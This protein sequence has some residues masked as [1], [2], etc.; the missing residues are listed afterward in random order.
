MKK[1][2]GKYFLV[3]FAVLLVLSLTPAAALAEKIDDI[4]GPLTL[5]SGSVAVGD[6]TG[7]TVTIRTEDGML[8][9]G[10][11]ILWSVSDEKT[12]A[13]KQDPNAADSAIIT[14]KAS[15][16][17][18]ITAQIQ[19]TDGSFSY[20]VSKATI[21]VKGGGSSDGGKKNSGGSDAN[22]EK[23]TSLGSLTAEKGTLKVGESTDVVVTVITG[24]S[25]TLPKG[26]SIKWSVSDGKAASVTPDAGSP[27]SATVK[28]LKAKDELTVSAQLYDSDGDKKGGPSSTVIRITDG[29]AAPAPVAST[30]GETNNIT[31]GPITLE[32]GS[33]AV[34]GTS[35]GVAT[36]RTEDGKLPAG[37]SIAWTSSDEALA[38]VTPKEGAPEEA[39]ITGIAPGAEVAIT[40]Q[41]LDET[42]A[43]TNEISNTV[44]EITGEAAADAF[45]PYF[46]ILI[47]VIIAV[48]VI[49]VA[50]L[51]TRSKRARGRRK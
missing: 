4:L 12:A 7:A 6:T 33:I 11:K 19:D 17:V 27:D 32:H 22:R 9:D 40:A 16:E 2:W 36:I 48:V 26:M 35:E 51:V 23:N 30:S 3:L 43:F 25:G 49:V 47:V 8:P 29:N 10:M 28:G 31:L 37:M 5:D 24:D 38:T 14:G 15:G 50:V 42:G 39:I 18:M 41:L 20:N 13:I 45:H 44:I 46:W 21:Q 1:S 34:G